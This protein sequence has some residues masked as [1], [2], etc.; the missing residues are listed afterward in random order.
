MSFLSLGREP[1]FKSGGTP[2]SVEDSEREENERFL[3]EVRTARVEAARRTNWKELEEGHLVRRGPF[4]WLVHE[5]SDEVFVI[6]RGSVF[7][8]GRAT[9]DFVS[10]DDPSVAFYVTARDEIVLLERLNTPRTWT[11]HV[12]RREQRRLRVVR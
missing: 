6:K 12:E 5:P 4:D 10:P 7:A 11:E 9:I 1:R 8:Q 3:E 2:R